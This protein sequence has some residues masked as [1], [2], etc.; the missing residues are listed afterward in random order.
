MVKRWFTSRS[1]SHTSL[2]DN[3]DQPSVTNT[4]EPQ[5][6]GTDCRKVFVSGTRQFP[7]IW[8]NS[9]LKLLIVPCPILELLFAQPLLTCKL[10]LVLCLQHAF[11]GIGFLFAQTLVY[12]NEKSSK[13]SVLYFYAFIKFSGVIWK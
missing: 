1:P 8:R 13:E 11:C 3:G 2:Q 12:T 7:R 6:A 10:N 9:L 4:Q 5:M